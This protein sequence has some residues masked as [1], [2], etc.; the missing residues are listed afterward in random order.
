MNRRIQRFPNRR[1]LACGYEASV[2]SLAEDLDKQN[3]VLILE[4]W[5]VHRG[6]VVLKRLRNQFQ[7]IVSDLNPKCLTYLTACLRPYTLNDVY[8]GARASLLSND[9]VI[10]GLPFY[11]LK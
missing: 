2:L 7:V 1:F 11:C 3:V 4:K 8:K 5:A 6:I 10:V 9:S